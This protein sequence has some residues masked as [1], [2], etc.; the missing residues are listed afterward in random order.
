MMTMKSKKNQGKLRSEATLIKFKIVLSKK[1]NLELHKSFLNPNDWLNIIND[2]YPDYENK[3]IIHKFIVYAT[4][5]VEELEAD[6]KT[7]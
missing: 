7:F 3:E 2:S 5:K 6:L 1:G 4:E